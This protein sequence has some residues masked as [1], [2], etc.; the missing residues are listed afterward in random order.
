MA[1]IASGQYYLR[2]SLPDH[3]A[4]EALGLTDLK[5]AA[6]IREIHIYGQSLAVGSDQE[7]AAQHLGLGSQLIETAARLAAARGFASLAV[8][9]AIGTR[10]YYRGR[11]FADGELYQVRRLNE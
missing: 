8:I 10:A 5:D 6:M 9:S 11:G 4:S 3:D 1:R 2:L 7:G